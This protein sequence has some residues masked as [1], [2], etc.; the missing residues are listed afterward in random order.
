[1]EAV[2]SR[3]QRSLT[4]P[5]G[6]TTGQRIVI[7]GTTG[8][9][10]V[11]DSSGDPVVIIGG[12]NGP[13]ISQDDAM[14][15]FTELLSGAAFFGAFAAG[16]ADVF[17][18]GSIDYSEVNVGPVLKIPT[19][20]LSSPLKASGGLTDD[21]VQFRLTPG[22]TGSGV[23][24]GEGST[25]MA[26]L[27]D[28]LGTADADLGLSGAAYKTDNFG[29]RI[30]WQVPSYNANW[31]GSTVFGTVSGAMQALQFSFDNEDH[32]EIGGCFTAAAGAGTA[33]CNVG[34]SYVPSLGQYPVTC[35]RISAG[36]ATLSGFYISAA[37]NLNANGQFGSGAVAGAQYF[38]PNQ[39]IPLGHLA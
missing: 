30:P 15:R 25:P 2:D 27:I 7:D 17:D 13:I 37:G 4:I 36:V 11:Y 12:T 29:V 19:L 5:T 31:S 38:I 22:F 16:V 3:F 10:T 1:M 23:G 9:I 35:F 21:R 33:V 34:P 8:L 14:T 6:A 24:G 18:A 39:I 20:T 32:I 26:V 28:S